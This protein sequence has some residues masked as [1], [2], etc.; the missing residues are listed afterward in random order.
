MNGTADNLGK[1]CDVC[2]S[3]ETLWKEEVE[4]PKIWNHF[5]QRMF[6]ELKGNIRRQYFPV[7]LESGCGSFRRPINQFYWLNLFQ[8]DEFWGARFRY[9]HKFRSTW[10][11]ITI[12]KLLCDIVSTGFRMNHKEGLLNFRL[13][14]AHFRTFTLQ[15]AKIMHTYNTKPPRELHCS[16]PNTIQWRYS[17]EVYRKA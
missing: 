3:L 11:L 13:L 14:K 2:F 15:L 16:G 10:R 12:F 6:T 1:K 5:S 8:R 17:R 7:L 4:V 9:K